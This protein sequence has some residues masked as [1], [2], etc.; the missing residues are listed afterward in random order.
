MI[1]EEAKIIVRA[2]ANLIL[3]AVSDCLYGDPHQWSNRPCGTCR[4]ITLLV[5]KPFGCYR[6]QMPSATKGSHD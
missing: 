1:D 4:T 6:Y 5:G 2:A 3:D